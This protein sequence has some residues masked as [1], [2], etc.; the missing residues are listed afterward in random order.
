MAFGDDLKRWKALPA[1]AGWKVESELTG[2][3]DSQHSEHSP[4]QL[5]S[6]ELNRAEVWQR[7]ERGHASL[8]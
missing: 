6:D 7:I 2:E 1:S 8:D 3:I 4:A 5:R